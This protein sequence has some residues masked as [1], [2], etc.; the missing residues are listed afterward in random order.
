MFQ[1]NLQRNGNVAPLA[2]SGQ[3]V[4]EANSGTS[5]TSVIN[6]D[7]ATINT[8][9]VLNLNNGVFTAARRG[10]YA[11]SISLSLKRQDTD[12]TFDG[13][14][15]KNGAQIYN[16]MDTHTD[17]NFHN[18]AYFWMDLLEAG[19]TIKITADSV[20]FGSGNLS[21]FSGFQL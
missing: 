15:Y 6:Y 3:R 4:R 18:L 17:G 11:L 19:D 1:V 14:V 8:E 20:E 10:V 2:F 9:E 13:Y 7:E 21:V 12:S 5:S 16:F